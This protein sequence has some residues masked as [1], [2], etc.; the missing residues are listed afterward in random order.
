MYTYLSRFIFILLSLSSA[1]LHAQVKVLSDGPRSIV[2]LN[3]AWEVQPINGLTFKYPPAPTGWHAQEVPS[4]NVPA[5]ERNRNPYGPNISSILTKDKTDFKRKDGIAGWFRRSFTLPTTLPS[6]HRVFLYFGGMAFKTEVWFNGQRVGDSLI[7]QLPISFDVTDLV[8]PGKANEVLV[9]LAD[10]EGLVDLENQTFLAPASG[11]SLGIWGDVELQYVPEVRIDDVFVKTSVKEERIDLDVTLVNASNR[12][13]QFTVDALISDVMQQPETD[14]AGRTVTLAPG[15][16]KIVSLSKDWIAPE[17]WS[18]T[19]PALYYSKVM[20]KEGG[21]LVDSLD[22][23]FGFREFE[24]RGLDFYLNGKKI[25]LLRNSSLYS[26]STDRETVF[27]EMR[28]TAGSP[29]NSLR[30]H[31]GFNAKAVLDLCDELGLLC[32]PESAWHNTVSSKTPIG[33]RALWVPHVVDYTKR[34][35]KMNRN[36][37]SVAMWNLTNETLWGTTTDDYM[38]VADA[39]VTAAREVDP[40]RPMAGDGEVDWGG[41][42]DVITIHYPEATVQNALRATYP[43]SG[44]I[45]PNDAH[46]LRKGEENISWRAQFNWDRPLVIGE[47]WFPS[48]S[49]DRYTAFMGE[50]VYNWRKWRMER[51]DG[52]GGGPSGMNEFVKSQQIITDA[53][54]IDGVAG[55]NPWASAGEKAMPRLAVRPVDFFPNFKGGEVNTRKFVVFNDSGRSYSNMELQCELKIDGVTVWEKVIPA[56]V[57]AGETKIFEVPVHS[58]YVHSQATAELS[59]RLRAQWSG[60]W[61]QLDR[62]DETVYIMRTEDFSSIDSAKIALLDTVGQTAGALKSLGL[63][64]KPLSKLSSGDLVDKQVLMVGEATDSMAYKDV[65][66]DFVEAGGVVIVLRQEDWIPFSGQ[67]PDSDKAHVSTR[68]WLRNYD[69]PITAGMSDAQFSYWRPNHLVS[70]KTFR[71]P[72]VNS[73]RAILDSGGLYGLNWSPLVEVPTSSGAFLLCSLNIVD[74]VDVEPAAARLLGNMIRYGLAWEA[75]ELPSLQLLDNGNAPLRAALDASGVVYVD[76]IDGAGPVLLDGTYSPSATEVSKLKAKLESGGNVWLHGFNN[77][78]LGKVLPLFPFQPELQAYD[79]SVQSG[80]R[81]S[82]DPLMNNLSSFD[83]FWTEVNVGSRAGFFAD[84]HPSAQLGGPEL[85]LP[86]FE[87]AETLLE[88]ALLVK[89]EVGEG[90]LL[91]DNVMWDSAL[92]AETDKVTRIVSSLAANQGA[93]LKTQSNEINY[94]YFPIDI[95]AHANMG[96]YDPIADD[97]QGGWTDQGQN[98]MRFFLINHLGKDGGLE[99]GMEIEAEEFPRAVTM[100]G[101]KFLLLDPRATNNKAVISLRGDEHGKLL[102]EKCEGIEVGDTADTLWF[103]HAAGWTPD[104]PFDEVARYV[105]H[106]TDGEQEVFPIHYGQEISEW[107]G[108]S[109]LSGA[110][111][112]WTG[113]NLIQSPVGIYATPWTNPYPEKEIASIDLIGNLSPTQ[114]VL[115]AITG[116][117]NRDAQAQGP[118][119]GQW[120]MGDYTGSVVPGLTEASSELWPLQGSP[121]MK[122]HEGAS[123]L[124]FEGGQSLQGNLSDL[125]ELGGIGSAQPF[126]VEMRFTAEALPSGYYAGLFQAAEYGK[127]G[128]RM[129]LKK[130]MKL[131]VQGFVEGEAEKSFGLET[132]A[133]LELGRTYTVEMQFDGAYARLL[134]DG[135]LDSLK[136]CPLPIPYSGRFQVGRIAGPDYIFN[137][138]IEMLSIRGGNAKASGTK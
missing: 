100:A 118:I 25:V 24:I 48:G 63:K 80:I 50:S 32:I 6:D 122:E 44:T 11:V 92:G 39:I 123:M 96:Y 30:L 54:R 124:H 132:T 94:D 52:R 47:Y 35:I 82:E 10:R 117:K 113:R 37:P 104:K 66:M 106:Y 70:K 97:G 88:P 75:Q 34:W 134:I 115:L 33:Q 7:G 9:G 21:K 127:S 31:I 79:P 51:M 135:R 136:A 101:R 65:I 26:L 20:V 64:L 15:E 69:H 125:P 114:I 121:T 2:D 128:V 55:V 126:S 71:K 61:N 8:R 38:E 119:L 72:A 14:I 99:S 74:R 120:N 53:Y 16:S 29:Y 90:T 18:T 73:F 87:A 108:P 59:V 77:E 67:L 43:N 138:T 13:R 19:N 105:I 68:S 102:P 41:R 137:G 116:G 84:G 76:G 95:S 45:L 78:T 56:A 27:D 130:D 133:P 28:K 81:R 129:M 131:I 91:F 49:A 109:P 42:L 83:F 17:L 89:I 3:G 22:T 103:L 1:S 110:K 12:A 46:W 4:L 93:R 98:D 60:S 107:W 112:A 40:T 57:N 85:K 36:R 58:P 111:V 5:L 23:R 62:Y 86:Y